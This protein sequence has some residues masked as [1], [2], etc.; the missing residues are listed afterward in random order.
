MLPDNHRINSCIGIGIDYK[1]FT[2]DAA[3][4]LVYML[5]RDVSNVE[6]N[7]LPGKYNWIVHDVTLSIGYHY[8]F[9]AKDKQE[10]VEEI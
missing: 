9:F 1:G 2:F 3:Y 10:P 6:G 4:M 5:E 8:D 7:P